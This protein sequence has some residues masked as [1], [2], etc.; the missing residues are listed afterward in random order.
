MT[1]APA[2]VTIPS[3]IAP[4]NYLIRHEIIALHLATSKGGAEFYPS[5]AQLRIGGNQKGAPA[6]SE[7]VS[8]PGAY[9][10]N[11]PGIFDPQAFDTKATYAFPGPKIAAFVNGAASSSGSGTAAP[12]KP[13]PSTGCSSKKVSVSVKARDARPQHL[14]RV[15]RGLVACHGSQ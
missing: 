14:S 8:L 7:L 12:S 15:M 1:G 4:G 6:A 2:S 5:C 10:D 3:T 11:D 13:K 9:S